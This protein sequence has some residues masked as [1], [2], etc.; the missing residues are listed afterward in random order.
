ML[1]RHVLHV[2]QPVV[3]Q[4]HALALERHLHAA[5]AVVAHHGDVAHL[6]HLHGELEHGQRVQVAV[7]DHIGDIA[8]DEHLARR[9]SEDLVGRHPRIGTADP[10]VLGRLLVGQAREEGG[11]FRVDAVHPVAV[12]LEQLRDGVSHAALLG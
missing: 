10:Q 2:A 9:Q 12:V 3:G 6:E 4:A 5:A 7:R 8:M 1:V 11:V